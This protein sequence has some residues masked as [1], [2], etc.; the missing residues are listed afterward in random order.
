MIPYAEEVKHLQVILNQNITLRLYSN[1]VVP[2]KTDTA[3]TYTEVTGGGYAAI[4]LTLADWTITAGSGSTPTKAQAA[5]RD[6]IFTGAIGAPGNIYGYFMT[7]AAGDLFG[8]ERFGSTV[9][10]FVPK[11]NSRIRITPKYIKG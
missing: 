9:V 8:A 5:Y 6:I 7:D 1:N 3:A 4:V 11:L 10:P 2:A